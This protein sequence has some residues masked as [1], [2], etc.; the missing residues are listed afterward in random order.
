MERFAVSVWKLFVTAFCPPSAQRLCFCR[1]PSTTEHLILNEHAC[2]IHNIRSHKIQ[3]QLNMIHP[4]IFP[5]LKAYKTKARLMDRWNISVFTETFPFKRGSLTLHIFTIDESLHAFKLYLYCAVKAH[6]FIHR[7]KSA[8]PKLHVRKH[9]KTFIFWFPVGASGGLTRPERQS[10]VS[11]QVP[12]QTCNGVA[13]VSLP[14][15][16][17]NLAIVTLQLRAPACHWKRSALDQ[18]L[19]TAFFSPRLFLTSSYKCQGFIIFF[20]HCFCQVL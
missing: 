7:E 19:S 2:T 10:G 8:A 4:E 14:F 17:S 5:Q 18:P 20:L 9:Q 16:P 3:A 13:K 12:A 6:C 15:N 11:A 1:F